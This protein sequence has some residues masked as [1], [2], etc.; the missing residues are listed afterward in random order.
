MKKLRV[1]SSFYVEQRLRVAKLRSW[2]R[3]TFDTCLLKSGTQ[4]DLFAQSVYAFVF[5]VFLI[6]KFVHFLK[7]SFCLT[8]F[9]VE[10]V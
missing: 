2:R 1:V 6:A 8:A 7:F 3:A 10:P 5:A 4:T 9:N